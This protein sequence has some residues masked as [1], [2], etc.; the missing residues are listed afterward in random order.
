MF[1]STK[2][3]DG[4]S[5][6]FRQHKSTTH[7][8]KLHGYSLEFKVIFEC[9]NLDLCN[10]VVDFGFLKNSNFK[11]DGLQIGDWFKYMFDHTVIVAD[12]DPFKDKLMLLKDFLDIRSLGNVGCESFALL[13]FNVL[14]LMVSKEQR[15]RVWVK[16]VEC[17]EN[18]KNS[19][20]YGV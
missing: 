2:I 9:E 8:S 12:D 20:V 15:G 16:S 7:C 10:W 14:S 19:A 11:F 4:F 6:C 18:K 13:V 1:Q 5:V 17:I 3:I